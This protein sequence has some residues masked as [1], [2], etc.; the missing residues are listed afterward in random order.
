MTGA[1]DI[2]RSR[3][4]RPIYV[5]LAEQIA[6]G[7]RSGALLPGDRVA[8]EPELMR[9]HS[10]SR[11][12]AV[13][14]LAHLEQQGLV[15][16]E[17][18]RGT[19]VET[20]RL[21][22]RSAELGSF[23]EEVRRHGHTPSQRLLSIG[24]P[25]RRDDDLGLRSRL[26]DDTVEIQ[27]LRLVDGEPV[28]VHT[29][30]LER[31]VGERAG[32]DGDAFAD[33]QASLYALLDAAGFHIAEAD[34]HLQAIE[35]SEHEADLLGV[36]PGSALMRVVRVSCGADGEPIEVVDA[37]Y[38]ADRFDYSVSLV[39]RHGEGRARRGS[40]RGRHHEEQVTEGTRDAHRGRDDGGRVR[41][42]GRRGVE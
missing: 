11:A 40:S 32:L 21:V 14:A 36:E 37:R 30:I 4:D 42:V 8:S 29:T 12:T 5:Q 31:I 25:Q 24:R 20:P 23:S 18:G 13:K 9:R 1:Q 6:D 27:R 26:G 7:I 15:R 2:T 39:R 28:G 19:F 10:I 41:Q 22:Q 16:R 35:A 33:D 38:R 3:G 34:E 17:Q